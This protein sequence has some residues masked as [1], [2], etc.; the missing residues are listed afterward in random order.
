MNVGLF[1]PEK[2]IPPRTGGTHTR[3]LSIAIELM[4]QRHMQFQ[5]FE[6]GSQY[7]FVVLSSPSARN[8]N[9][10]ISLMDLGFGLLKILF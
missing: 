8:T 1:T 5:T 3:K 7:Y 2:Q 9:G 6:N 10:H 4:K